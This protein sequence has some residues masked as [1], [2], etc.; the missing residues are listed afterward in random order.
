MGQV[1]KGQPQNEVSIEDAFIAGI[2]LEQIVAATRGFSGDDIRDLI[3][4]LQD[5]NA[6]SVAGGQVNFAE[7]WRLIEEKVSQHRNS[8]EAIG[9]H[10]IS[11]LDGDLDLVDVE[12]V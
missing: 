9:E 1:T 6:S 4:S 2:H 8:Q 7:A 10:T 3:F 12:L 11:Y 5:I